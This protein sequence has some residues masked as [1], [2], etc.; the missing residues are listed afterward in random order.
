MKT[1]ME[2][3]KDGE[4]KLNKKSPVWIAVPSTILRYNQALWLPAGGGGGVQASD[5][6]ERS[7]VGG[8]VGLRGDEDERCNSICKKLPEETP[9]MPSA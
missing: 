7:E 5:H 4:R 2:K 6:S 1:N 9:L 3:N 8:G